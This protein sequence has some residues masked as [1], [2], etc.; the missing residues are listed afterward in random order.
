[1]PEGFKMVAKTLTATTPITIATM[2]TA[3]V[4]V[5]RGITFCNTNTSTSAAYDLLII[6]NGLTASV[7]MVKGASLASQATGQPLSSTLVLNSGDILQA[8]SSVSNSIDVTASYLES[9]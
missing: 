8:R 9:Y 7:Y 3:S 2:G 6:P 1:M 4:A 5:F